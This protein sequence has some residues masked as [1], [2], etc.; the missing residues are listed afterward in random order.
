MTANQTPQRLLRMRLIPLIFLTHQ[1]YMTE[2]Y[3]HYIT[4]NNNICADFA[5]HT[6]FIQSETDILNT[7][8][9]LRYMD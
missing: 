3:L 1:A 8:R 2:T 7:N 6:T 9:A 4:F 5:L